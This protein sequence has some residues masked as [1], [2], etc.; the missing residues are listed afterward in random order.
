M[1]GQEAVKAEAGP[2]PGPAPRVSP[3]RTLAGPVHSAFWH[4]LLQW[5]LLLLPLPHI[6]FFL[7]SLHGFTCE[8]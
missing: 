8:L 6:L 4:L 2:G 7:H 1:V 5:L 3:S